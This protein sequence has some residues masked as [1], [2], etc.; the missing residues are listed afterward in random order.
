MNTSGLWQLFLPE[1]VDWEKHSSNK[2][3]IAVV[4]FGKMGILHAGI[5]NL[6]RPGCV[7]A[8]VER[9]RILSYAAGKVMKTRVLGNL[10]DLQ[11]NAKVD[12][13]YLTTPASSHSLLLCKLLN[14]GITRIFV[15]KPPTVDSN[16]LWQVQKAMSSS[17]VVMVG[18]Q[19]RYALPFRHAQLLLSEGV[20]GEIKTIRAHTKSS[21][22]TSRTSRFD[23]IGRGALLDLG[24]HVVDLL[25]C[26]FDIKHVVKAGQ[27]SLYTKVDDVFRAELRTRNDVPIVLEVTWSD[28]AYRLPETRLQIEGTLGTLSVTEDL[29]R[30]AK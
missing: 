22:I 2:F 10:E 16:Q 6:L 11:S 21:D 4:G 20:V 27:Q 5:L 1:L 8:I 28:K 14:S 13:A 30:V 25:G 19:K 15:E 24:I 17:Q 26:F 23:S 9:N 7:T 12:A 3:A 18:L 29:L